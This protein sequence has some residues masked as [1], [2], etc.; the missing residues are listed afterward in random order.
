MVTL[1]PASAGDAPAAEALLNSCGLMG[2]DAGAQFGP[3]YLLA[4]DERSGLVGMAGV[5]LHGAGGL[6]RSVA[7]ADEGRGQGTGGRLTRD[8]ID[9]ARS[10]GLDALYLLTTTSQAFFARHGFTRIARQDVPAAIAASYQW[11]SACP[12]SSVAM[13]LAL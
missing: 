12:G 5:E 1:R 4:I 3:Q 13:R 6:L 8:R 9:W 2:L 10:Q 7:V 11:S